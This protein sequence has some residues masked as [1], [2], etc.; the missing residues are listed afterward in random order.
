MDK[1]KLIVSFDEKRERMIVSW[2]DE[3]K[4]GPHLPRKR[5]G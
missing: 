3:Y 1:Y 5:N 4:L 2:M